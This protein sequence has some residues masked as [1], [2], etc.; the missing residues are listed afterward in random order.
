MCYPVIFYPKKALKNNDK[1]IINLDTS[2]EPGSHYIAIS[3]KKDSVIYFDS[4][5]MKCT[6]PY[7]QKSLKKCKKKIISSK[8]PIQSI[9]SLF[10]GFFL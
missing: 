10:C 4:F 7:I 9:N 8:S 2:K 3:I 5:G 6:N 1:Y